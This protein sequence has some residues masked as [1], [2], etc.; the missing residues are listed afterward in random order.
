MEES[1]NFETVISEICFPDDLGLVQMAPHANLVWSQ[2]TYELLDKVVVK[3]C[4]MRL[5]LERIRGI[6]KLSAC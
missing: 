1:P 6:Q 3:A 5:D 4:A 2:V